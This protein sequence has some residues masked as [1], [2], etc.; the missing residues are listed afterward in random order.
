MIRRLKA[1]QL[2]LAPGQLALLVAVAIW[3]ASFLVTKT[4][5]DGMG[6]LTVLVLRFGV[7]F[8]FLVPFAVARGYRPRLSLTPRFIAFGVTGI[9]LHNGLET[10]GLVYTSSAAAAM[11]S[12]ALPALTVAASMMFL[13]E[14]I[15][16]RNAIG[17]AISFAGVLLVAS[18]GSDGGAQLQLLGNVMVLGGLLSWVAFTIQ[19]K[20][21][22]SHH[23]PLV[24]TTAGVGSAL[25]FLLPLAGVE[26]AATGA[27]QLTAGGVASILY[28]AA[29]SSAVAYWLWN[30]AL[31]EMDA[32]VA[33]PYL[34]LIPAL[35]VGLALIVGERVLVEQLIGGVVVAVGVWLSGRG[36]RSRARSLDT[37]CTA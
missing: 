11:V 18:A 27:P 35:A 1:A 32:S 21:M 13:R 33:A 22:P 37:E 7:G 16:L 19:A 6:P 23:D 15:S 14:K 34:N 12:A 28:L 8:A 29:L 10:A 4:A 26:V 5:L 36:G 3:G 17:I 2:T 20:K 9:V 25:L 24:A 30:Q 31:T